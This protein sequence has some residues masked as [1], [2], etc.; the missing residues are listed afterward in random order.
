[1]DYVLRDLLFKC[2]FVF[3]DDVIVYAK[4]EQELIDNT[5][6]VCSKINQDGLKLGGLKCDFLIQD[7]EIL[8]HRVAEGELLP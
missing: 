6:L 4:D 2:C 7:V 5:R 1:M 8:G 3:I